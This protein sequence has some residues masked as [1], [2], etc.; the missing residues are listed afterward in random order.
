MLDSLQRQLCDV[1]GRLFA[2]SGDSGCASE[3]FI[4]AFMLGE[5]AAAYD[6]PYDRSQWMGEG[7]LFEEVD[8]TAGGLPRDSERFSRETLFWIGYAYRYWT[9]WPSLASVETLSP[10]PSLDVD[11]KRGQEK[12]GLRL[13]GGLDFWMQKG[14]PFS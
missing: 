14:H 9:R 6:R 11:E 2:L 3:P 4:R 13:M 8:K 5:T 1:Q 10:V 7:Y 12:R